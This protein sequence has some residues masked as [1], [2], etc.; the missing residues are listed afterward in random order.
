MSSKRK[1]TDSANSESA[2]DTDDESEDAM[3]AE[4]VGRVHFVAFT[5]ICRHGTHTAALQSSPKSLKA[6]TQRTS[7]AKRYHHASAALVRLLSRRLRCQSP[8]RTPSLQSGYAVTHYYRGASKLPLNQVCSSPFSFTEWFK[9]CNGIISPIVVA[10]TAA[11][12]HSFKD[13][14]LV[15]P[16]GSAIGRGNSLLLEQAIL[17]KISRCKFCAVKKVL[18]RPFCPHAC[19]NTQAAR[20]TDGEGD[21]VLADARSSDQVYNT[22]RQTHTHTIDPHPHTHSHTRT[23]TITPHSHSHSLRTWI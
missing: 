12:C 17:V 14:L 4:P 6:L 23:R 16:S 13:E 11:L 21:E 5:C 9:G 22:H 18:V 19:A 20:L 7:V 3:I 15:E 10:G 1:A 8:K 2:A